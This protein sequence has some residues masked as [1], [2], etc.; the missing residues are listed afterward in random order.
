MELMWVWRVLRRWWW[1]VLIPTVI[2]GVFAGRE[3]LSSRSVGGGFSTTLRYS[4]AQVLQAIPGRDGDFQD[5]WLA[6]E[7][8]VNAL[9]DWVRSSSFREEIQQALGDGVG[10]DV[11]QL[12]VVADN[13]RSVGLLT[14][15]YP[16]ADGL[17]Q[18]NSAAVVVLQTR[19]QAYFPQLGGEPAQVTILD[20]PV[21][22]PAPPPITN[23]IAPLIRVALALL[24]GVGLAFLA[25]YL[26][27]TV[28]RREQVEA[29]GV[30]VVGT[31][32]KR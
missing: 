30:P 1:L 14:L 4:A 27:P 10:V 8:T 23:R 24:A 19:A 25:E 15:S 16:D 28:Q 11:G 18:I 13:K 29:L 12:G 2:A 5:V 6:S 22:T 3:L 21:V 26:D 7:L 9:T 31:L 17:A 20:T 32:P